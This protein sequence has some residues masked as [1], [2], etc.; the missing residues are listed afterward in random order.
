A[1]AYHVKV[2]PTRGETAYGDYLPPASRS[3]RMSIGQLAR[4]EIESVVATVRTWREHFRT[5][6]VSAKDVEYMAQAF[7]PECFFFEKPVEE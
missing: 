1:Q 6:G 3:M 4:K 2:Y 5:C 7:L